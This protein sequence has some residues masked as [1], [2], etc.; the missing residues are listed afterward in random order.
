MNFD[1]AVQI[2]LMHEGGEIDHPD[3][4]GGHTKFGI[5]KRSFPNEDI[6]NLTLQR[7][8][9]I[10]RKYYWDMCE[11]DSL[12]PWARLMV[13]DCAVNQGLSRAIIYL[14]RT[15]SVKNDG[16]IGPKTLAAIKVLTKDE[17]LEA[18]SK[19]RLNAYTSNP[20]WGVFGKGWVRRLFDVTLVSY[21]PQKESRLDA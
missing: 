17:F 11:C 16:I 20:R 21:R 15:L 12:T 3:D 10:Y 14:Q 2:V 4:P 6:A 13:F 19:L 1:I 18:Y 8:K 5:S 7:A 9:D